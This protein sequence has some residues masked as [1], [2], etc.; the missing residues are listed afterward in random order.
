MNTECA[1]RVDTSFTSCRIKIKR[2]LLQ[3]SDVTETHNIMTSIYRQR[4]ELWDIYIYIH[5]YTPVLTASLVVH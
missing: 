5:T 3:I 2:E 1:R 4:T